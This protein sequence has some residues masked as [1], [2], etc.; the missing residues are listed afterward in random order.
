MKKNISI[1]NTYSADRIINKRNLKKYN[2]FKFNY[3]AQT[4][5][6]FKI[7]S[8]NNE[9]NFT[10]AIDIIRVSLDHGTGCNIVIKHITKITDLINYFKFINKIYNNKK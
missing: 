7:L 3:H 9:I 10:A 6:A 1:E 5:I 4:L 2:C 8:K